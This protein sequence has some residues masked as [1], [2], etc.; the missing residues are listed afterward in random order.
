MFYRKSII[1]YPTSAV[2]TTLLLLSAVLP[3][4]GVSFSN[5]FYPTPG[6]ALGV[7]S[8]DFN[9]DG[10]P[11]L[12]V[13]FGDSQTPPAV[14]IRL[15]IGGGKFGVRRDFSVPSNATDIKTADVNGGGNLDLVIAHS[16]RS[17]LT[18]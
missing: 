10:R 13:L 16:N 15:G 9:R 8:G 5:S 1:S 3:A 4:A 14:R 6:Q 17:A 7:A 11:D 18:V 12:A 2:F